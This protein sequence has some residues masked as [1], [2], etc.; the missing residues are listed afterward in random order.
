[1]AS[2]SVEDYIKAI[3]KAQNAGPHVTTQELAERMRVSAP[4]VSKMLKRLTQ[5]RLA[6]HTPYHGVGL[7][8]AGEK[9]ALEIIRHHRLLERY[10]TEALGYSWEDVHAEAERL[11]HY[12][13][14]EFEERI[15]ALLGHPTT[16]PH[17]DPI[18]TRDGVIRATDDYALSQQNTPAPLTIRRVRDTD[19]SLL[20][21]LKALGLLPGTVID[22][23]EQEPFGGA[24][25]VRVG[26]QSVRVAPQAAQQIFV[27]PDLAALPRE[28]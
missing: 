17:G 11:E 8:E 1:M 16:C 14:E 28:V 13:S 6:V 7:T 5:L 3:Y 18:P 19:A 9:M 22:F 10:L 15:D 23:V 20:R 21:H 2:P 24:Y 27:S 26:G 25:I 12:I 4:A